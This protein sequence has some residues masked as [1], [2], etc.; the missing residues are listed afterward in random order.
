MNIPIEL[1]IRSVYGRR[2]IYPMCEKSKLLAQLCRIDMLRGGL[3]KTI[4]FEAIHIIEKLGYQISWS[5]MIEE[6]KQKLSELDK[7]L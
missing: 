5:L 2:M 6:D 3:G 1:E 4:P 7:E